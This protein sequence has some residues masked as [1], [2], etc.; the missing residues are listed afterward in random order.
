MIQYTVRRLLATIPVLLLTSV[1]VFGLMR[2]IPGDPVELL[3]ENAFTEVS[4]ELIEKLRAQ[5]GL[6]RPLYVQYFI[7]LGNFLTGDLGWSY[8]NNQAVW[9]I[10]R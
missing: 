2:L 4:D 6:D 9:D 5:H 10:I 8:L 1:I 3:V 7:W